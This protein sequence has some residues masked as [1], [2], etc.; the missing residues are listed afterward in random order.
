MF[1]VFPRGIVG[2]VAGSARWQWSQIPFITGEAKRLDALAFHPFGRAFRGGMFYGFPELLSRLSLTH[3][4]GNTLRK[5]A[6]N[7]FTHRTQ[8]ARP[9]VAECCRLKYLALP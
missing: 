8:S 7:R 9:A 2:I 3:Q 5:N 6:A 1:R 4:S